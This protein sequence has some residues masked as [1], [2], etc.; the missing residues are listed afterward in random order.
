MFLLKNSNDTIRIGEECKLIKKQSCY[1]KNKER[2]N[3]LY[4]F[5]YFIILGILFFA[6]QIGIIS[7]AF[8]KIGISS[9]YMFI[10][11]F[12]TLFG[13]L[14]N[15]PIKRISSEIEFPEQIIQFFGWRFK[16]PSTKYQNKTTIA[17]NLSGAIVPTILSF[18]L[19][20]KR[21]DLFI[22]HI[23]AVAVVSL[24]IHRLARPIRGVGITTPVLLPP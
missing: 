17:V 15:I 16:I 10:L 2:D 22:A 4:S 7:F 9:E 23:I 24:I 3:V 11:L 13:S 8:E 19:I 12:L 20:I 14:I 5:F 18:Y 21:L 1:K 6:L